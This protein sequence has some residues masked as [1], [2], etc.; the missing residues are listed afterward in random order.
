MDLAVF[1]TRP[2]EVRQFRGLLVVARTDALPASPPRRAL[3]QGTIVER[4][5]ARQARF[6]RLLVLGR[7]HQL[8]LVGVAHTVLLHTFL[9]TPTGRKV[10]NIRDMRTPKGYRAFIPMPQ[11]RGSS[12]RLSDNQVVPSGVNHAR[13]GYRAKNRWVK[14]AMKVISMSR[15]MMASPAASRASVSPRLTPEV[16]NPRPWKLLMLKTSDSSQVRCGAANCALSR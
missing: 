11:G 7:W 1:G 4:A 5:A 3:F 13:A 10:E 9:F 12:A 8:V 14:V 2:L 15:P 6:Q 16:K